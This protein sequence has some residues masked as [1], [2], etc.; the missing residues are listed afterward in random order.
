MSVW[1]KGAVCVL[2]LYSSRRDGSSVENRY[3]SN[4]AS[5]RDATYGWVGQVF[6]RS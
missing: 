2:C 1:G 6:V 4:I 5:R 3:L